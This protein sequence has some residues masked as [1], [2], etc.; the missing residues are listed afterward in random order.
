MPATIDIGI[1]QAFLRQLRLRMERLDLVPRSQFARVTCYLVIVDFVFFALERLFSLLHSSFGSKLAGWIWFLSAVVAI[2]LCVLAVRW[3]KTRLLWRLRNRLIVTYVFIGAIPV[4]LLIAMGFIS[5]YLF[6]GQFA[7][8]VVTSELNLRLQ[9]LQQGNA[10]I[11]YGAAMRMENGQSPADMLRGMQERNS[12]GTNRIICIWNNDALVAPCVGSKLSMPFSRRS[13]DKLQNGL[14]VQD[15]GQLYL[16]AITTMQAHHATLTVI[17]SELLGHDLLE[18]IAA[19]LGEIT[20]YSRKIR[21]Q[22]LRKGE[23]EE[24]QA[25]PDDNAEYNLH[26]VYSVGLLPEPTNILDR[27]IKFGTPLFVMDWATGQRGEISSA[28]R[29]RTRPSLLYGR[30]FGA[31]GQFAQGIEYLLFFLLFIFTLIVALAL[32]VGGR[33]TRSMTYAV[34]QLYDATG[35][36]NRGDLSHRIPVKSNDQLA[37]LAQSFNSMT[38]SLDHLLQEQREKQKLENE[39]VIAQEVQAQLFPRASSELESLE[40]HGFC[41]PAR[42]VSGDY[43]DFLTVNSETLILAVGDVSGKG[44]SAALLMATIHSAVRAYSLEGIPL[45]REMMAVGSSSNSEIIMASRAQGA[46]VSP[47]KLLALLNH[48][49]YQSTPQEKYATMFL[50]FY[51]GLKRQL[52]YSNAGHLPPILL[53]SDG[54]TRRLDCGGTVVGMFDDCTY[55]EASVELYDGEIFLAYSDGVTEPENDYGEFGEQRL[56]ELVW[57]NRHLSLAR[58]TEIVTAAVDDWIGDN[59]QPDDITLVLARAR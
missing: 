43:Y 39:L 10:A 58:I 56:I 29:V 23:Q 8:F 6:A 57:A 7:N 46:E 18:Q 33:L 27:E 44:I 38:A 20:L 48:Q 30:L 42:T 5:L 13:G 31:M 16:R 14:L 15:H 24:L 9:S 53:R 26:A 32:V 36:V 47:G 49:L 3:L 54:S 21:P 55:P 19:G 50:G 40:V 28:L 12:F 59:E 22:Q 2:M 34:A 1:M 4:V 52:T 11:A 51:D 37:E 17:S 25:T 41:R 35:R 45:V